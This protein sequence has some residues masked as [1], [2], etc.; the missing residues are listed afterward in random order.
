MIVEKRLREKLVVKTEKTYGQANKYT[1][2][3]VT[4]LWCLKNNLATAKVSVMM[5]IYRQVEVKAESAGFYFFFT[6]LIESLRTDAFI[7]L[8]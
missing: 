1:A 7:N 5:L 4:Y 2:I 3:S 8:R 6:S